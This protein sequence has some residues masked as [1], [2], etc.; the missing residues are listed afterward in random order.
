MVC[1][2]GFISVIIRVVVFFLVRE[3]FVV[4]FVCFRIGLVVIVIVFVRVY[5]IFLLKI[6]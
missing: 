6:L 4:F 2:D 5:I 1:W 3:K